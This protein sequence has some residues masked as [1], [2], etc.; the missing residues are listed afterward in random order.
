M[1][2]ADDCLQ[3][4]GKEFALDSREQEIAVTSGKVPSPHATG[5]EDVAS[6]E[7]PGRGI[8]QA[9]ASGTVTR[10]LVD[11][12]ETTKQ[13][14]PPTF[15]QKTGSLHRFHIQ[16]DPEAA[17]K[18]PIGEHLLGDR[19]HDDGAFVNAGD[20]RGVPDMVIVAMGEEQQGDRDFPKGL[21]GTL[22][23]IDQDIPIRGG[24]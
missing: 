22:G 12:K 24:D 4:E 17:E 21:C 15:T 18:V 1:S 23:S 3:G 20:F 6:I 10:D 8:M 2:W 11:I 14:L 19:V 9:K 5:K 7:N 13:G 16:I